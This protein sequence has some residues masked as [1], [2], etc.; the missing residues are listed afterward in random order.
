MAFPWWMTVSGIRERLCRKPPEPRPDLDRTRNWDGFTDEHGDINPDHPVFQQGMT[1][2]LA[3]KMIAAIER[4]EQLDR[5]EVKKVL[6]ELC[7]LIS[8]MGQMRYE[9]RGAI[10]KLRKQRPVLD[11]IRDL[12]RTRM[13]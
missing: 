8:A 1:L 7:W 4:G 2:Y 5:D 12:M 6:K 3:Q 11:K 13:A 9:Y 10:G